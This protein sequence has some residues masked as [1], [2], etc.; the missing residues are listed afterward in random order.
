M[1]YKM[2]KIGQVPVSYAEDKTFHIFGDDLGQVY[3]YIY[4]SEKWFR[5]EFQKSRFIAIFY[6]TGALERKWHIRKLISVIY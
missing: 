1:F 6:I 2:S 5:L 3:T 4:P